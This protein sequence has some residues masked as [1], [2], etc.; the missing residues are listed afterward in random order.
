M[1]AESSLGIDPGGKSRVRASFVG[2]QYWSS[3][4]W[5]SLH[6]LNIPTSET[7][8]NRNSYHTGKLEEQ[9]WFH[10]ELPV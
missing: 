4:K 1:A 2:L 8:S 6:K 3:L 5:L 10:S 9:R 7:F